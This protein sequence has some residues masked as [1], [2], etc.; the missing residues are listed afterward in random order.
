MKNIYYTGFNALLSII[1]FTVAITLNFFQMTINFL[2]VSGILQPLT[3]LLPEKEIRILT[4]LGI[5]FLF[6]LV[7]SGFKLISDMIWQFALLLF[8]KDNEGIDLLATK[9]YSFVFLIGGLIAIF[10][11]KSLVYIAIILIVSVIAFFILF[12][13]K[14]R[15]NYT[16][17]GV[18]GFIMIQLIIWGLVGS[19]VVYGAFTVLAKFKTSMPF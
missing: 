5:A 11:N 13:I 9:K 16:I 7:L 10:L 18:I 12:L 6:Y 15:S 8:S 3:D 19:G 14:Q 2:S 1:M 17:V 4:F